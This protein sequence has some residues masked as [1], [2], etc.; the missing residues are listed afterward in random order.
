[1][2]PLVQILSY[3]VSLYET[4]EKMLCKDLILYLTAAPIYSGMPFLICYNAFIMKQEEKL[5]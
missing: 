3:R 2:D 5:Q 1:V 4:F